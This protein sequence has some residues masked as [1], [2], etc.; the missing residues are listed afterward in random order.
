MDSGKEDV[1]YTL[2]VTRSDWMDFSEAVWPV[3]DRIVE[4]SNKGRSCRMS[5]CGKISTKEAATAESPK[6]T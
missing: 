3:V 6:T 1:R 5:R 2:Q 4:I